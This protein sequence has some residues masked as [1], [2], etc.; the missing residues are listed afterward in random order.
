[1]H[2][3]PEDGPAGTC[4]LGPGSA[5]GSGGGS[6]P[7]GG[8]PGF[9][10]PGTGPDTFLYYLAGGVGNPSWPGTS[11]WTPTLGRYWSHTYA[12]RIV[13]DPDETHVWLIT[14]YGTF[15]EF[16]G[17]SGG[18]YATAKPTDEH[19]KLTRTG[20]GW[21]LKSLDGT[22][23]SFDASGRWTRTVDRDGNAQ[24]GDYSSGPLTRVTLPDGR[25]EDFFYNASGKLSEI[26]QTGVDGATQRSWLYTWTG[27]D[28]TLITRPDGTGL[29][30]HYDDA[31]FPGYMT[32]HDLVST[33]LVH[34]IEAGWELDVSGNVA[35]T[36]KGDPAATGSNAVEIYT[37]SYTNPSL[38]T[39][40]MVTDPLGQTTTYAMSR[41]SGS[42]KP[43]V[44]Q[45]QGDCPVCGTGPNTVIAYG[46]AANP[47]MPTQTTDGRGLI[48]QFA[49]N[50]NGRMTSKTEAA[51]APLAR[52]TGYQ[53]GNSAFPAFVT[54]IDAPSTS[55]GGATRTTILT[56]NTAGDLVTRT[57]Q[58]AE[59]GSSFSYATTTTF[60][61]AGQTLTVDPPGYGTADLTTT[62]YDAT[63]GNLLP[64]TR[65]DPLIG[66]TTFGYDAFN[67]RTSVTDPNGVQTVTAYDNLDRINSVTQ[68]GTTSAG[69]LVTSYTYNTFGDL[70]RTTLPR[71]NLIEYGYDAAGR[72]ISIERRPDAATHGDRTFYTLDSYGHRTK[73]ELQSWNGSAWVPA[74]STSYV[75][76]SRCHLDKALY[77][78]GSVTEYAYDCD[79]NLSQVWDANHPKASNPVA[80][81]TYGYDSLNRLS[82]LT[83]P[84]GGSGGGT[85]VTSYAYDVQ[86]HLN[87]V[88]DAEGNVT[89][90]VYSDRDLMTSQVSPASGTTTYAY[91][92]H[93]ELTS[94]L[95]ARGIALSRAVDALDRP[96]AVTYP[97]PDLGVTYTYDDPA[98][99][100]SKGRLTR[101]ARSASAIDYR[102][103]RF[104]R[105]TQDGEL[106]YAYDANGN[107]TSLVYPEG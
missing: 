31:R 48:T 75:Y 104:G 44:T 13:L 71:G 95:D 41:D 42:S 33:D 92:E 102:Y 23:E 68:K 50:A 101:I 70:F 63:R 58:G 85:A 4:C 7:A 49:Y 51:G 96:T 26:R 84:W 74:S 39:Q 52:T 69:D 28:L 12:E 10:G 36:W 15:R 53:Y 100:F 80:T 60:N 17:L 43:K 66:D 45:I 54:E 27:D 56:Y 90:Y 98:V 81:Q 82:T 14:R 47:L 1:V 32:R 97:T 79:N 40:S 5:G 62:T 83:Q 37:F 22:V 89:T 25:R 35:R 61:A 18:A 93:G 11:L 72:L 46:D 20:T 107:P 19:R 88:T 77:P 91:N 24:V 9:G 55:G 30:F 3:C 106:S 64:L 76:S 94:Q 73:E 59:V 16:S 99:S 87:K 57:V 8:G 105:L 86:D 21:E 2:G 78:D 67:R 34:R 29:E 6:S 65:T 38:P 103:D